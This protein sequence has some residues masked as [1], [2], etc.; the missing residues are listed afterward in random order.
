MRQISSSLVKVRTFVRDLDRDKAWEA[1]RTTFAIVGAA[2][3]AGYLSAMHVFMAALSLCL[4][5]GTWYGVYRM[6]ERRP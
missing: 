4:V 2:G 5:T 3:Y 6:M 1:G